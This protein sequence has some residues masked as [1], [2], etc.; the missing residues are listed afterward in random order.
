MPVSAAGRRL[1]HLNVETVGVQ[2]H[3]AGDGDAA[4]VRAQVV[5]ARREAE[6]RGE[7]E[8]LAARV[9]VEEALGLGVVGDAL[10]E[11]EPGSSAGAG[12]G[13]GLRERGQ[14]EPGRRSLFPPGSSRPGPSFH[15]QRDVRDIAGSRV[16]W[17]KRSRARLQRRRLDRG[18]S[19]ASCCNRSIEAAYRRGEIACRVGLVFQ[20]IEQFRRCYPQQQIG[21]TPV[22]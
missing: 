18:D 16:R 21:I 2:G 1:A 13:R 11:I 15:S 17:W 20:R 19:G 22:R 8:E 7:L 3:F 4:L 10:A 5:V 14:G 9:R 12:H 6:R